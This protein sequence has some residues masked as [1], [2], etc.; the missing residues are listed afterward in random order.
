M[1]QLRTLL[2]LALRQEAPR[3]RTAPQ[4]ESTPS[5]LRVLVAE[6]NAVNCQVIDAMLR[7][8]GIAADMAP[9]GADAVALATAADSRYDLILMDCEMPV[10]DGYEAARRIRRFEREQGRRPARIVALSAHALSE[11]RHASLEAGM[12]SHLAKPVSLA[13]LNALLVES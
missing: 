8:L 10:M 4:P 1:Q 7:R 6:D 9:N 2:A 11:H 12:D 3:Q 5:S 13:A